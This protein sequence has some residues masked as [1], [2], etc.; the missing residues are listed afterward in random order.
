MRRL[1]SCALVLSSLA[2]SGFSFAQERGGFSL[3]RFNPSERG[4]EWFSE[5]TLD[6]RGHLRFAVGAV[7]DYAHKPLVLYDE[8]DNEVSAIVKHQLHIHL[9]GSLVLWERLRLGLSVPVVAWNEGD[10]GVLNG[11]FIDGKEGGGVGDLRLAADGR[12][13]GTYGGP[14]TL[15]LG[16]Q[17]HMPTGDRE[18]FTGDGKVRVTPRLAAAGDIGSF[19]YAARV[20]FNYR[21]QNENFVGDPFGSEMLFGAAAGLRLADGKLLLGPEV[22]GS[23]VVSDGGDGAFERRTTPLEVIVGAHYTAGDVRFGLGAGP[24]ITRGAGA[25]Q[26]RVLASLEYFPAVEEETAPRRAADRDGDGIVDVEDACPDVPGVA[27]DEPSKHGCPLPTDRDGDGIFDD[28]DACPDEPGVA[29]DDPKK[30][31]CPLPPDRDGDGILDADDACPDEPGVASDEP[32]KHGCPLPKDR[33]GDG[34]LDDDDACPDQA[35]P[36][37]PDPKRHGCPKAQ[38]VGTKIEILERVEFDTNKASIRPESD[39]VLN[40]VLDILKK[41]PNIKKVNVEGHTD[42]RGGA[43]HN[44]GLSKRRA[45]AVVKWLTDRGID[46]ERLASQGFGQTKPIDTNDTADGRQNNRRVE[47][48]ILEMDGPIDVKT[49]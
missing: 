49:P 9:G 25:P 40:A 21:A 36:P 5:D 29:S 26:F 46:K 30:H 43:G 45:A 37:S 14:F 38:V 11:A 24:G 39:G 4:S 7:G 20:G 27:S 28:V 1:L 16:V 23:T 41:Y 31:G 10:T 2:F 12:L 18:A 17:A 6:L 19:A 42:N 34:I 47:F 13:L 33:D 44:L 15:A 48:N 35:G 8:D 3:N 22:Y 32:S